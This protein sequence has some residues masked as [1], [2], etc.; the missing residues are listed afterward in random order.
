MFTSRIGIAG[1]FAT[2]IAS[3]AI[4]SIASITFRGGL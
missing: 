3:I 2:T 1:A 4:A